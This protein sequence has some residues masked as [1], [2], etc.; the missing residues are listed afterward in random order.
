[1]PKELLKD[2]KHNRWSICSRNLGR[3]NTI[4]YDNFSSPIITGDDG[5][6]RIID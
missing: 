2:H 4:Q 5:W 6:E 3:Y 1:M